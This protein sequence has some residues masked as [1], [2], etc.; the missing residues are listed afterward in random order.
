MEKNLDFILLVLLFQGLQELEM[1]LIRNLRQHCTAKEAKLKKNIKTE[2]P[3][4]PLRSMSIEYNRKEQKL[5][6]QHY[7]FKQ[8]PRSKEDLLQPGGIM[9]DLSVRL[10][11]ENS[12]PPYL[13]EMNSATDTCTEG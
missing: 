2:P 5:H 6:S 8:T 9:N 11:K 13:A 10:S 3:C 1:H 12:H 4:Q 7:C